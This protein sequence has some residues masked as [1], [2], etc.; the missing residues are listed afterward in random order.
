MSTRPG[1]ACT[2]VTVQGEVD[3]DTVPMLEDVLREAVDAGARHVVL[4]LA[5]VTFMDSSGLSLLV[6]WLKRLD[7]IGGRLC[8]AHVQK[9]VRD[10]LV[11]S[12][13]DTV[14]DVYDTVEAA[15]YHMPPMA[16]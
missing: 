14:L 5:G 6:M 7:D 13:L 2:V 1:R 12:A 10:V 9:P 4:D 16:A 8:L 15:E 11:L 3:V